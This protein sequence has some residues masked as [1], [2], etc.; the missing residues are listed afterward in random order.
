MERHPHC[1]PAG[2]R[3]L[4]ST[5]GIFIHSFIWN[6]TTQHI[7]ISH[8][9]SNVLL[10]WTHDCLHGSYLLKCPW[11]TCLAQSWFYYP[12][13]P[14]P[15]APQPGRRTASPGHNRK[16]P[17]IRTEGC[18]SVWNEPNKWLICKYLLKFA[19]AN[20]LFKC[21]LLILVPATDICNEG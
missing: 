3:F 14:V 10:S 19:F 21:E 15:S 2:L 12:K 5:C 4:S 17:P 13:L 6:M 9:N 16:E 1:I 18:A 7:H 20:I 8:L 11:Q